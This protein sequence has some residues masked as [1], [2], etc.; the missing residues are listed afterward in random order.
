MK[1]SKLIKDT[2]W[3]LCCKSHFEMKF[4]IKNPHVRIAGKVTD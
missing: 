4:L 1:L 3:L 2:F